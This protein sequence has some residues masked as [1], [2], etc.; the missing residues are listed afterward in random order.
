[1]SAESLE[2]GFSCPF[3]GSSEKSERQLKAHFPRHHSDEIECQGKYPQEIHRLLPEGSEHINRMCKACG[4]MFTVLKRYGDDRVF[5]S[6]SCRRSGGRGTDLKTRAKGGEWSASRPF[7]LKRDDR[8]CQR[9]GCDVSN[10][11]V[12]GP[13]FEVHHVMPRAAGGRDV[14]EN[15]ITLCKRCHQKVHRQYSRDEEL[16][17]AMREVIC[18]VGD[19][20]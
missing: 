11:N 17:Q 19:D 16:W 8:T 7:V 4:E 5:C 18:G 9:C 6:S 10:K 20:E 15:L 1:M 14:P 12:S 2:S 3:C 13:D